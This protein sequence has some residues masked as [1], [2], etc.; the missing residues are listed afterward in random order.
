MIGQV[1]AAH[2]VYR[3]GHCADINI[4]AGL[5]GTVIT[6]IHFV[7]VATGTGREQ[8]NKN[9]QYKGSMFKHVSYL[10]NFS[11]QYY[12]THSTLNSFRTTVAVHESSFRLNY[13]T[14]I[15][16]MGSCFT[17]HI[18]NKL[19]Y[20][21]FPAYSNP[22]GIVYNPLSV[23]RQ[24]RLLMEGKPFSNSDLVQHEGLWHSM[25]H[26]G[27]FSGTN[28]D[29]VLQRIN[30]EMQ[31]ASAHLK[32][33]GV[34]FISLGTAWVYQYKATGRVVSNCHKMPGGDFKRY[35]PPVEELVQQL[36]GLIKAMATFNSRLQIVF[37]VSPVRH[38]KD[39][40]VGNQ[41]SKA[42]LLLTVARLVE[43]FSNVHYFPSYEIMMDDLRDYRFYAEDMVH[44]GP[45]AIEYIWDKFRQAYIDK[46]SG[47]L[48]NQVEE[49]QRAKAHRPFNPESEQHQRF[50]KGYLKKVVQL[51]AAY[52][53]LP[54]KE[55]LDY[56]SA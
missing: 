8:S 26:H 37:T 54:L 23:N 6:G 40:A 53:K 18:G 24:L 10:F 34:L 20:Y 17:E 52:P 16:L 9:G 45:L 14:G 13:E 5:T 27:Q 39:G 25:E 55:E 19:H 56:F 48:M 30:D 11:T 46:K 42:A 36:S 47:Q 32:S 51:K 43:Q 35:M 7:R 1:H 33:S 29:A 49:L 22:F 4:D 41:Q 28:A 21:K 31:A 3:S 38:L 12:K 2:G 15:L 50:L 44:P